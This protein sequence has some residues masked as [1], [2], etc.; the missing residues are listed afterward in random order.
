MDLT[1]F[2]FFNNLANV[3][4]W[5]DWLIVFCAS[6]LQYAVAAVLFVWIYRRYQ[7]D[8]QRAKEFSIVI[9][10]PVI[11]R[12]GVVEIIR[13]LYHRPRP[14]VTHA[15][16]QLVSDT[17]WSFPSGH[18]TFFFALATMVYLRNAKLGWL[19]FFAALIISLGRVAAGIHYPSDILGG[20][21]VGIGIAILTDRLA[22]RF[23]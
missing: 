21:I 14:Y 20:A 23:F 11:A 8:R 12:L 16:H 19:L 10:A 13:F 3:S 17:A 7:T 9:L 15:V 18:A 6:F 22:K 2:Y 5:G 1:V 4:G